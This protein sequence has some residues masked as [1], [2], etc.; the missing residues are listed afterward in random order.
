MS[1]S[2]KNLNLLTLIQSAQKFIM[3]SLGFFWAIYFADIGL[4]GTQIGVMFSTITI[5]GL[6]ITFPIGLTNDRI[7]SKRLL[8][9]GLILVA[10]EFLV[11]SQ[12]QYFPLML[13]IFFVGGV[14]GKLYSI[15]I[16]SLFYKT[17]GNEKPSQRIKTYV[18]FYLL[19]AGIGALFSG[20]ILG[21]LDFQKYLLIVFALVMGVLALSTQLPTTETF[22][23][24]LK[25]YKQDIKKPH[26][27]LFTSII[28]GFA[29]H[30][31]SEF[32]SYAPFLKETLGLSFQQMGLYIGTAIAF[33]FVSVRLTNRAIENGTSIRKI[34]TRGLL[35]SGIG[36]LIM[37]YPNIAISFMGRVIHEGGDA[38]MFVFFYTGVSQFFKK[39]RIGG[40]AGLITLTQ[41]T[42][43]ALSTLIFG[44]LG[45]S[46][47]HQVPIIIGAVTTLLAIIPLKKY[48]YYYNRDER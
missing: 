17:A 47:G 33:M 40:N 8:Q 42:A 4:T 14:G 38:M 28:F 30:M 15:S 13:L 43:I 5:T 3:N 2:K 41:T 31:G 29:I 9:I 45:A 24:D 46:F 34:V 1:Q 35:L 20:T 26:V 36:Y 22:K 21:Y 10:L 12:T 27:L 7:P 23:F 11:M 48:E 18:S 16:D 37:L 39:K 6:F 44:P 32:T 25:A 19:A